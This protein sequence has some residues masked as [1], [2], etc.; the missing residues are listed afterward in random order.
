MLAYVDM[1]AATCHLAS[2]QNCAKAQPQGRN[3]ITGNVAGLQT[4][5]GRTVA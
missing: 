3:T 1:C 4:V 2:A 5:A